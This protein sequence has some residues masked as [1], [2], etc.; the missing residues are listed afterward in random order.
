MHLIPLIVI[1]LIGT[2]ESWL[3][4]KFKEIVSTGWTA[5]IQHFQ[6]YHGSI[7]AKLVGNP[8]FTSDG[9]ESIAAKFFLCHVIVGFRRMGY[10]LYAS[11][12][13]S[14]RI[15]SGGGGGGS[16]ASDLD[17]WVFRKITKVWH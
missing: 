2:P 8:W 12:D 16:Y 4:G 1:S 15:G 7:E 14:G 6:D 11:V 10:K 3:V 9:K 13:I 17:V 5:G